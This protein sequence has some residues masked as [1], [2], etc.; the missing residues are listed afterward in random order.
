MEKS[1]NASW[2]AECAAE[3]VFEE[4][5]HVFFRDCRSDNRAGK[6]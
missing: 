2:G 1:P 3:E 4:E 5:T 6:D